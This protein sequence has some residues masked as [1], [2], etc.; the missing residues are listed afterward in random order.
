MSQAELGDLT[1]RARQAV[2]LTREDASPVQV[3]AADA[4]LQKDLWGW[5]ALDTEIDPTAAAVAAAHWLQA[6]ADVA[7]EAAG[8]APADVVVEADNIEALPHETPTQILQLMAEGASP[9]QAVTRLVRDAMQVA[10][11]HI[12]DL[13][14]LLAKVR[15][16]EDLVQRYA[17][18]DDATAKELR[19]IQLTP[20][21]IHRPSPDLLED[22][23]TGIHACWLL[24]EEHA[25]LDDL[26][27]EPDEEEGGATDVCSDPE[28]ESDDTWLAQT[29]EE[30]TAL[31]RLEAEATRARLF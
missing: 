25:A 14:Q 24:Y 3:A 16:A 2:L 31:V 27:E 10:E 7:G 26:D 9:H 28:A 17:H 1:G 6:A 19:R 30:F 20:L 11:G 5:R 22:L 4:L 29:R 12:P 15:D 8:V 13:S 23:L 21:D 18:S